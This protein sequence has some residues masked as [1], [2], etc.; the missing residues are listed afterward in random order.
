MQA[1]D[2]VGIQLDPAIGQEDAQPVPV[3]QHVADR[4]G[5]RHLA[6]DTR[7]LLVQVDLE[8]V[9]LGPAPV[10][11]DRAPSVGRLAPDRVLDAVQLGNAPEHLAGDR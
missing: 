5:H 6:G 4:L 10:L 2:G 8:R 9:D 1:L 7:Q 11:T 3:A